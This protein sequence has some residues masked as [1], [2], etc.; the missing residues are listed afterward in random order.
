MSQHPGVVD[1]MRRAAALHG[2]GA[3]GTRNI[4]GTHHDLVELERELA[5]LHGKEA[6]L[7]FTSGYVANM[8]TLSTLAR[9]MPACVVFSDERNHASMIEGIRHS[10]AERQVFLHSDPSDLEERLLR[11]PSNRPKI[12]ALESIY[13][14]GGDVA[15]LRS[16]VD[17][18]TRHGAL[19]Y[20]DEVH[21][22]GLCGPQGAGIAARD[23]V[24]DGVDVIQG[25][26]A[27]AFGVVGGY[28][29]GSAALVDFVRSFA[30]GFIF[31]TALP[32][33]VAAAA[34]A[35]VRH[36]RRSDCERIRLHER[37]SEVKQRLAEAGVPTLPSAS[38]IVPIPVGD[39]TRC[40]EISRRLLAEHR[41]LVQAIFHPTV[42]RGAE[43]LRV[44]P[45]PMHCAEDVERLVSALASVW[46]SLEN[47]VS[48]FGV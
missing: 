5:D 11:Y 35:S 20:L 17:V 43:R 45:T 15:P 13:S 30:S 34:L 29:A 2:V 14:M 44:T 22:V 39:A 21:A 27:K 36:L 25:N 32:P 40:R 10:G 16:I 48:R 23:G 37:V 24:A 41:I 9:Q 7:V 4:A 1:A 47:P 33:P 28:I 31:T 42:P 46:A 38:H 6:A 8:A 12:V 3:G 26:L 19:I 18:A